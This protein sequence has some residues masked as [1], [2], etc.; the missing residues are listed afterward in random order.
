MHVGIKA[1]A[2]K[3]SQHLMASAGLSLM[4][5]GIAATGTGSTVFPDGSSGAPAGAV[6]YATLLNSYAHIPAWNV[7]GV[8][9]RVGYPT[10]QTFKIPGVD[11]LPTGASYNNTSKNI[12]ISASNVTLDGWD[13]SANGGTQIVGGSGCVNPTISNCKFLFGASTNPF[14]NMTNSSSGGGTI[15][16]NV[17]DGNNGAGNPL[18]ALVTIGG[19]G[20]W[21]IHYNWFKN[22]YEDAINFIVN[23]TASLDTQFNIIENVGSGIGSAHPDWIQSFGSGPMTLNIQYNLVIANANGAYGSQGFSCQDNSIATVC[24]GITVSNNVFVLSVTPTTSA[25]AEVLFVDRS[26]LN[27]VATITNNYVDPTDLTQFLRNQSTNGGP[28]SGT[29]VESGNINMI[30]G[31]TVT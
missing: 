9:Y 18:A 29:I 31:A 28:Y 12:T 26:Q 24:A 4:H 22:V 1:S 10:G 21:T 20:N 8:G 11:T 27:G 25:I 5:V 19:A 6:Q 30:T 23:A 2:T 16:N 14:I 13:C 17:I 7:A 3:R 15:I